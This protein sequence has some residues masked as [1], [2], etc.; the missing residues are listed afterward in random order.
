[1]CPGPIPLVPGQ[2]PT[3]RL[4]NG[5]GDPSLDSSARERVLRAGMDLS[6]VGN[7][8]H[9]GVIQTRVVYRDLVLA[10]AANDLAA[11]LG[12][13][14]LFDEKASPVTDLTVVIGADFWPAG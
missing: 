1:M 2:R 9:D 13:G 7:Y 11:A 6:V 12:G 5:T 8:R 10:E 3:V 14:T 4:R